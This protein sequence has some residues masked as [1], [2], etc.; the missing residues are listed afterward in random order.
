DYVLRALV[1]VA[2][3]LVGRRAHREAAARNVHELDPRDFVDDSAGPPRLPRARGGD[4]VEQLVGV[5]PEERGRAPLFELLE[6]DTVEYPRGILL[7]LETP[8]DIGLHARVSSDVV[9]RVHEW[10]RST[11]VTHDQ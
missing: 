3:V 1:V 2:A 11:A 10:S 6:K 4:L 8:P 9:E 5:D 7:R